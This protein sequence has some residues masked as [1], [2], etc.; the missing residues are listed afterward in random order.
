MDTVAEVASWS[1]GLAIA[2]SRERQDRCQDH[3]FTV[4][5]SHHAISGKQWHHGNGLL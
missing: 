2:R 3:V 5:A 4:S 1:Y